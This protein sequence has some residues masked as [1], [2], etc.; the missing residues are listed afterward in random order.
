MQDGMARTPPIR[1]LACV[2]GQVVNVA[3]Q[4]DAV[5]RVL[6]AIERGRGFTLFTLNLDHLVKLRTDVAFREAYRRAALV[7][8]DGGPIVKLA[9]R[10][11]A[12][13]TRTTGADLVEP[14]CRAA[15]DA[16]VPVF[17]FGSSEAS[18]DGACARL[19]AQFPRLDVRGCEAPPQGFDPNSPAAAAAGDRIHAS[20]ARLCFVALGAPKQEVFADRMAARHD[21]LGWVCVGAALDFLAGRQRRAPVFF[22]R[23]GLEWAWR[24]LSQP[25][26]LGMRY[27]RCARLYAELLMT[28]TS[29]HGHVVDQPGAPDACRRE[30]ARRPVHPVVEAG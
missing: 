1:P 4:S 17:L 28:R 24:M 14:L 5:R 29:V 19:K 3:T 20:G 12:V 7:T 9:R 15:E 25:R 16:G 10:A 26:R 13:L 8:A 11:G 30:D 27:F 6:A 23:V 2:D 18:L 21:G 22:Q